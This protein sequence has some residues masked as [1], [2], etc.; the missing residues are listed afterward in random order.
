L[1]GVVVS[2]ARTQLIVENIKCGG[3]ANTIS[4]GLGKIGFT[5]IS[6]S[7]EQSMVEVDSPKAPTTIADAVTK[8][9][10]LGYPLIETEEGLAAV[11]L[12]AKSYISCAIGKLS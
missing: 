11:A 9:R 4:K 7:P 12:K 8:L 3:C 1:K 2:G 5:N 10:E 6:V